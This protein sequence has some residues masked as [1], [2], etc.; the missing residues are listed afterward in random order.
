MQQNHW[1]PQLHF[2][3]GPTIFSSRLT[4]QQKTT[5]IEWIVKELKHT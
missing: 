3:K 2:L 5:R 1:L 4:Q